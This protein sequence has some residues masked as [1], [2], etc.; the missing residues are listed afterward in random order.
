M[1]EII[2]TIHSW[3]RRLILIFGISAIFLAY[4]GWKTKRIFS[5]LD[6]ILG[7]TFMGALHIQLI[8]GLLLYFVFSPKT[9]YALSHFADAMKDNKLRYFAL[10][11]GFIMILAI[12]IAQ[13]GRIMVHKT[14]DPRLKHKRSF[15]YFSIALLMILLMVPFGNSQ[16]GLPLFRF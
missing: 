7:T 3:N 10:E 9:A 13:A 8:L 16:Q 2:L 4:N 5:P 14:H 6:N 12:G 1:Y 15:I 11:H